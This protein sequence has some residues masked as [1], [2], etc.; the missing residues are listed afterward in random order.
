LGCHHPQLLHNC[1]RRRCWTRN[2]LCRCQ[3][4]MEEKERQYCYYFFHEAPFSGYCGVNG[5]VLGL[6]PGAPSGTIYAGTQLRPFRPT[7]FLKFAV[8]ARL[9]PP[10]N[11]WSSNRSGL[12]DL[13]FH[14]IHNTRLQVPPGLQQLETP[15][16]ILGSP[17]HLRPE[18]KLRM[19]PSDRTQASR[20]PRLMA[21][22]GSH[23]GAK[24]AA[25]KMLR[26]RL[27]L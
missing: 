6:C 24:Q 10:E 8:Y 13:L 2:A 14:I 16:R 20:L 1:P 17:Q 23:R 11:L 7:P 15:S 3:C 12:L 4:R 5:T 26:K 19:R 18:L 21:K 25:R 27:I 22:E 9:T